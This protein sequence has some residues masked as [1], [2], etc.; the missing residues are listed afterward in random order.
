MASPG[1]ISIVAIFNCLI[2]PGDDYY[3]QRSSRASSLVT[4]LCIKSIFILI[5]IS[6]LKTNMKILWIYYGF[7]GAIANSTV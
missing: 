4:S 6:I 3:D 5:A 7:G 2:F 1:K